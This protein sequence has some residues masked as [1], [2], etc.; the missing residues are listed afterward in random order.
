MKCE[1]CN[2]IFYNKSNL[3]RH[4][5][6]SKKCIHIQISK[7]VT[8]IKI[9][10]FQCEYCFKK[11]SSKQSLTYHSNVCKSIE[12]ENNDKIE[13]LEMMIKTLQE[14][15]KDIKSTV[16]I[17]NN[18]TNIVDNSVTINNIDFMS[19]MSEERIKDVFDNNFN[20]EIL[21]GA[22]KSLAIF[23]IDNFLIGEDKPIYLCSDK[24]RNKFYFLDKNNKRID[25]SNAKILSNLILTYGINSIKKH[26]NNHTKN[27]IE[28]PT[29]LISS[30]NNIINL[31]SDGK[32]YVNQLSNSLPK[33]I[34]E[35]HI[36]DTLHKEQKLQ[37]FFIKWDT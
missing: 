2:T 32:D 14:E 27:I 3:L 13:N 15:I 6:T 11:L 25:D 35:R 16:T 30:Y 1:Y 20:I 18:T 9:K 33:T 5:T 19:Y 23:T 37:S 29:K 12:I 10:T 34:E 21:S 4:Q 28:K 7:N 24:E 36:L 17:I 31:T 8:N 26:Y 22:E